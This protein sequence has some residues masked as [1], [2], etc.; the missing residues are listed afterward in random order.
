MNKLL[1]VLLF[2]VALHGILEAQSAD[3]SLT[4]RITDQDKTVISG[5]MITVINS[6][7][8][9]HYQG[10]TNET[11]TYYISE[12]PPGRSQSLLFPEKSAPDIFRDSVW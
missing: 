6:G 4:G 7:T 11:G 3:A 1:L 9:I 5:A 10:L 2:G 12:L 8:R